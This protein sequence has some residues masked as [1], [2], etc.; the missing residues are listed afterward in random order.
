MQIPLT[1]HAL[2]VEEGGRVS[3]QTTH[4]L[5]SLKP[6]MV[7]VKTHSVALNPHDVKTLDYYSESG[8]IPGRDFSGTVHAVGS[9]V[10]KSLEVGDRVCG[11]VSATGG[12]GAFAEFVAVCGD[13][14]IKIP[15]F[16][17]IDEAAS[18]GV[19]T[20]T[21]GLAL[22]HTWEL[23]W[24]KLPA[25]EGGMHVLVYGELL[26]LSG[27]IPITT[28]SPRNFPLVHARG[29]AK[30]FDYNSPTCVLD[31]RSYCGDTLGYILDCIADT[32]SS[33][34][35]YEA[36]ATKGGRYIALN[37]LPKNISSRASI[38]TE[39]TNVQTTYGEPVD[40]KGWTIDARPQDYQFAC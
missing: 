40:W 17:S 27:C 21:A 37:I 4:R 36:M 8:Y 38:K 2:V 10:S 5:P 26:R 22:Y 3:L 25:S 28:C 13:L 34:I 24:P 9:S 20:M 29:A 23:P 16:M 12:F 15:D 6:N 35:C 33:Q 32:G 30:A 31:I 11:A 1:Q 14:L 18:L 7:L 39:V 19:G